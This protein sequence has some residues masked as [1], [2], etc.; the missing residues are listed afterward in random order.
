MAQEVQVRLHPS[1]AKVA[2]PGR[3]LG[4]LSDS[5]PS[6]RADANGHRPSASPPVD[7]SDN[8]AGALLT[9]HEHKRARKEKD[10]Q[11]KVSTRGCTMACCRVQFCWQSSLYDFTM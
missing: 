11:R 5:V 3:D 7:R 1:E 6:L 10:R 9:K 2:V 4:E 8:N